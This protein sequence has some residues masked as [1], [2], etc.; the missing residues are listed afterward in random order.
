L[1]R[2]DEARAMFQEL[3]RR[4]PNASG[5]WTNLGLAEL[6][7]KQLDAAADAFRHAVSADPTNGEAWQGL[8]AAAV[9]RD[10]RTAID[11][12]Q[13]AERLQPRDYDLL[14][15]LGMVLADSGRRADALPYLTRFLQEAPR[16]RY[17][18]DFPRVEA[19]IGKERR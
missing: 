17:A 18:A 1:G 7:A 2:V 8:G 5:T 15:N 13:H 3:L 4:D 11:A 14:F 12:W 10:V 16:D 19:A 9:G 6:S